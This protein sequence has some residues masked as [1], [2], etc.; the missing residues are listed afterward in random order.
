MLKLSVRNFS[1]FEVICNKSEMAKELE[2]N[3]VGYL[4]LGEETYPVIKMEVT[5]DTKFYIGV[6][7][8]RKAV[9]PVAIIGETPEGVQNTT[10]FGMNDVSAK[11]EEAYYD[12]VIPTSE[13]WIYPDRE[14]AK[15]PKL[16]TID[17]VSKWY[18]LCDISEDEEEENSL[19]MRFSSKEIL[20]AVAATEFLKTIFAVLHY[21]QER[22][23][24]LKWNDEDGDMHPVI[25]FSER[26]RTRYYAVM[27][28]HTESFF[29]KYAV[30]LTEVDKRE[31]Y[32]Y[33]NVNEE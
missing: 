8:P 16:P 33:G 14:S 24:M 5:Y 1:G 28:E 11:D 25:R 19:I 17:Q 29:G 30:H 12:Y 31:V 26:G 23:T 27:Y 18:E 20:C 32:I 21:R 3:T 4:K 15:E 22:F 10:W 9:I 2:N 13:R 6:D 7:V